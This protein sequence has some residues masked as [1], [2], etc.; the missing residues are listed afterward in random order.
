M[1]QKRIGEWV[2]DDYDG[3]QGPDLFNKRLCI[4]T[5]VEWLDIQADD[6]GTETIPLNAIKALIA[7]HEAWLAKREGEAP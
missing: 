3:F 7:A 2:L 5:G 6:S 4:S 1:S